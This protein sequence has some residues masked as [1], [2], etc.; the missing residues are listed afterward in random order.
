MQ[1]N[2]SDRND[3][4]GIA[5][6][7]S[8]QMIGRPILF[9]PVHSHV[10]AAPASS[11]IRATGGACDLTNAAIVSGSEVITPSRS[12]FPVNQRCRSLSAS[13]ARP[14]RH[15]AP[16]R[17]SVIARSHEVDLGDAWKADSQSL[18]VARARNYPMCR[19]A[20]GEAIQSRRRWRGALIGQRS[21][22]APARIV[23]L[24]AVDFP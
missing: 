13:A 15:S 12:I 11:P 10:D 7:A 9:N 2:K 3:A 20:Q 24:G 19:N 14:V 22:R 6:L 21:H 5:R 8:M 23:S 16:L 4:L 17:L 18:N 1:I